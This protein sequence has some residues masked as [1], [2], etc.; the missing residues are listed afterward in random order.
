MRRMM[1]RRVRVRG[2]QQWRE[3]DIHREIE[4]RGKGDGLDLPSLYI[5]DGSKMAPTSP[6]APR[7]STAPRWLRPKLSVEALLNQ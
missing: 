3:R 2:G 4:I 7:F 5:V 6:T 1:W